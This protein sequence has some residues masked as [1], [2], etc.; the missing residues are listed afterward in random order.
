M[1]VFY[2]SIFVVKY[3]DSL[4]LFIIIIIVIYWYDL[5]LL[6][7]SCF[8]MSFMMFKV[9]Y[10]LEHTMKAFSLFRFNNH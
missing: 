10:V 5:N 1:H 9:M 4:L 8:Y 6:K 7:V 2:I 3:D